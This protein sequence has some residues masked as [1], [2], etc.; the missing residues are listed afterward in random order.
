MK[1]VTYSIDQK[2]DRWVI[3]KLIETDKG[4]NLLGV[5]SGTRKEC[6]DKLKELKKGD[7]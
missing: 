2:Q 1:K 4:C 5:F 7:K 6:Q 3:H